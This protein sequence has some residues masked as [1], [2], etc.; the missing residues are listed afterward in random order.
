MKE[1]MKHGSKKGLCVTVLLLF[2]IVSFLYINPGSGGLTSEY[3]S[4][5]LE[6][7][8]SQDGNTERTDYIGKDGR[9]TLAA[10]C[11]YAT[12]TVVKTGNV[13]YEEYYDERGERIS[14][15]PGYYGIA[16]EYDHFGNAVRLVYLD[17]EGNPLTISGGYA[18]EAR[19]Y[20]DAKRVIT[21]RYLD[22]T[23]NPVST[24]LYGCGKAYEYDDQGEISRITY[25]DE[26]GVPVMTGQGFAMLTRAC[27]RTEGPDKGK[28]VYEYYFDGEGRPCP[29]SLGQ[30]GVRREYDGNGQELVLTYLDAAGEPFVT[31]K[32]YA[33]VIRTFHP[34]GST[35]TER[36]L[37]A[38]GNAAALSEGQYGVSRTGRKTVYLNADGSEQFNLRNLLYN[39]ARYVILFGTLLVAFSAVVKKEWNFL[40]LVFYIG[41][42]GYLTLMYREAGTA[43]DKMEPFWSYRTI[44]V[45]DEARA[46]ILKNI[47]LFIPLGA[48]LYRLCPGKTGLLI[49]VF[50]SI[51]IEGIQYLTGIGTCE[52]D[53]VISNGLGGVAGYGSGAL[54]LAMKEKVKL[55]RRTCIEGIKP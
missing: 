47:W 29:L 35:A 52:L 31:E 42:I 20:N 9:I 6:M 16:R 50:L 46:D 1:T 2:V 36:Y 17:I 10:D 49:P 5:E 48:I 24:P 44:L 45:N 25:L 4:S 33:A 28:T 8:T 19:E 41:V 54:L 23:G 32:G 13:E 53:D 34:D 18:M 7:V 55:L 14:Q 40:F 43:Q 38:G 15:Y 12:R 11:G 21:V 22:T 39:E 26:H 27:R 3:R 30:Y 51:L 37:D